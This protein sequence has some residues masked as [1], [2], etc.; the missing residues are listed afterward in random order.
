MIIAL[1]IFFVVVILVIVNKYHNKVR[2]LKE[3]NYCD[4][5][6][7]VKYSNKTLRE[8]FGM[9]EREYQKEIDKINEEIGDLVK[10]TDLGAYIWKTDLQGVQFGGVREE[11]LVEEQTEAV[12]FEQKHYK[13]YKGITL[14]ELMEIIEKNESNLNV[15][16]AKTETRDK[17]VQELNDIRYGKDEYTYPYPRRG[18]GMLI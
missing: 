3:D 16:K 15:Y 1:I 6:K 17:M 18:G 5:S 13:K 10:K 9:V 12:K 14:E 4:D 11:V 7:F 8:N 2:K